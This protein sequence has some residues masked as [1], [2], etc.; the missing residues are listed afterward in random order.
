MLVVRIMGNRLSVDE[1]DVFK[2]KDDDDDTAL[3]PRDA[4]LSETAWH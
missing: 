1:T 4:L 2:I 3:R